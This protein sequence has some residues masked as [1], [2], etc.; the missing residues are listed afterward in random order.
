MRTTWMAVALVLTAAVAGADQRF[1][2]EDVGGSR[3]NRPEASPPPGTVMVD[4][5]GAG[6]VVWPYTG[7]DFGEMLKDPINVVFLGE[8]DPRWIRAAL[9]AVN[10]D[11]TAFGLPA[12]PPF[13]C[14][15]TDAIGYH[16]TSYAAGEWAGSAVQLE[17]GD[18]T[19]LRTHLRLFRF[20]RFTLGG[21]HF[22][23]M[24][25]GTAD[26]FPFS[27]EFAEAMVRLDLQRSGLLAEPPGLT[28]PLSQTP[29]YRT[30]DH[31]IVNALPVALRALTGLPLAP[32][33]APVPIPNDGRA[34]ILRLG[35]APMPEPYEFTRTLVRVYA[36]VA[37]RPFCSS[38][39]ADLI[40]IEGPL[41]MEH[42]V[43]ISPELEYHAEFDV[44]GSLTV[45]PV[46][47]A[48]NPIGPPVEGRVRER[49]LSTL[50]DGQA[51]AENVIRRTLMTDPEQ[52]LFQKLRVGAQERFEL[53]VD[54]GE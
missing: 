51:W 22:E 47:P 48:G 25:P 23:I 20:G 39:P 36:T 53:D 5:D 28:P 9:M 30:I 35:S 24:P 19:G 18:Y 10:G 27:W 13:N 17:C 8:T 15:W 54:C 52:A 7:G 6:E 32:Q 34:S 11:R 31:R 12:A 26:H 43:A 40:R 3:G 41:D 46:D 16:Q 2:S 14:R 50:S 21:A 45:T 33:S 49:Q 38:G 44:T 29:H 4:V 42:R 37:P 1:G